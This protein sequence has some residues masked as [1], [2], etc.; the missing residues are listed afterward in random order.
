VLPLKAELLWV[1]TYYLPYP[2]GSG[3]APMLTGNKDMVGTN[4]YC[5][6]ISTWDKL[7]AIAVLVPLLQS[8]ARRAVGASA[9]SPFTQRYQMST[10]FHV[11]GTC[12]LVSFSFSDE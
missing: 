5:Q 10:N 3:D 12:T 6:R 2:S 9:L 7:A 1:G 11:D 4:H 8:P